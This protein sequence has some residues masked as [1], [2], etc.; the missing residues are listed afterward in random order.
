MQAAHPQKEIIMLRKTMV[1][2]AIALALGGS[3]LSTSAFARSGPG[4][5]GHGGGGFSGGHFGGGFGGGHAGGGFHGGHFGG[6]F[7]GGHFARGFHG[8]FLPD[9]GGGSSDYGYWPYDD[10]VYGFDD[11]NCYQTQR[12]HTRTGWHSR[13]VY[14]CR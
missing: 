10:Y 8:G 3:A 9:L 2:L 11:Q 6:G 1:V 5:G 13:Q 7:G 12:Y 4:G 14:V